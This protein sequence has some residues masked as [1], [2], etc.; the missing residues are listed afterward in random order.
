MA[1][2]IIMWLDELQWNTEM[3]GRCE[4]CSNEELQ[5]VLQYY[6]GSSI[7]SGLV[8]DAD[9]F[10]LNNKNLTIFSGALHY[11]RV[12][13]SYWEDRI[14][15]ISAMGLVAVETYV[16]WNLHEPEEGVYDFGD[17]DREFSPFLD[18]DL[19]I[20]KVY[21]ANLLLLIRP[22]PY[23][24]AEWEFGGL[25]SWLLRIPDIK[26][27]T[28]DEKYTSKVKAYFDKLLP[29]IAKWQF[30][31]GGPII[32][33][34]LENEYG[35]TGANDKEYLEFLRDLYISHGIDGLFFTSD[36]PGRSGDRGALDG[37][38]QTA[39][40]K[41]FPEV[42]LNV[43]RELQPDKPAMV[44]E[45]W[46]GWYDHWMNGRHAS[47]SAARFRNILERIITY[48]ASFNLYM[49]H[50]GTSF[51]FMSGANAASS[52]PTYKPQV[53]SYDYDA[54][55]TEAGDYTDKYTAVQELL[56]QYAPKKFLKADA[57]KETTK[58]AYPDVP[59][60][61][62]LNLDDLVAQV[63]TLA[64]FSFV[65]ALA[66][67][68]NFGFTI[69][70]R[71]FLYADN[72]TL[73]TKI[74]NT[75]PK[76]IELKSPY[77][78][79]TEQ[80]SL[81]Q[82]YQRPQVKDRM[83]VGETG[84]LL[85]LDI[86]D[87]T[88]ICVLQF[89]T[90][91]LSLS[92]LLLLPGC[93]LLPKCVHATIKKLNVT[94]RKALNSSNEM[95]LHKCHI[96]CFEKEDH[97]HHHD[98]LSRYLLQAVS[99]SFSTQP[100]DSN[101]LEL[102]LLHTVDV[103]SQSFL[104]LNSSS[105][106]MS[107]RSHLAMS[108]TPTSFLPASIIL[109]MCKCNMDAGDCV[110]ATDILTMEFLDINNGNGQ[111]YGFVLYR[112]NAATIGENS[113]LQIIGHVRDLAVVLIDGENITEPLT[114]KEQLKN[115]GFWEQSNASTTLSAEASVP[116]T[117]D[118]LVE[119]WGRVNY[120]RLDSGVF[121][122]RKGIVSGPVLIDGTAISDWQIFAL[123]F[124][125]KWL[126]SLTGWQPVDDSVRGPVLVRAIFDVDSAPNDTFIDM[127]D[128]GKGSVFLNGFPLG[129]Y[130]N[131]GPQRTLYV[132]APLLVQGSNEVLIFELYTP[133]TKVVFSDSPI[134]G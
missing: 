132:P 84:T 96:E 64:T 26:V 25:P 88:R 128:W 120:G 75:D 94:S 74:T 54:P 6:Q 83:F 102:T 13:P 77:K 99:S 18:L 29:I 20:Q 62:Q 14:A 47:T 57:P 110:N 108:S 5:P 109:E 45:Y 114:S 50:G 55:L 71:I 67:R 56:D 63:V 17:G 40:F 12:H 53:T 115:F 133:S 100:V 7:D 28:S 95:P 134:L 107:S 52:F 48:P 72:L 21:E 82:T 73:V 121:D 37:V 34:Q 124:K 61:G 65:T 41:F 101:P 44:M 81:N 112:K 1:L 8:A 10:H 30:I 43:L 68:D 119:N 131:L 36:T 2:P 24:C 130:F 92:F 58:V 42:Q 78:N 60:L 31:K 19:F 39:N 46:A 66:E 90:L 86:R 111:S 97:C 98:K 33:V 122:Q 117:L 22:G 113:V 91:F 116:H 87:D 35:G 123:Q 103:S 80:T 16:P 59:L 27:R 23:I 32:A 85:H 89:N 49:F 106:S 93:W 105:S 79:T 104:A 125:K 3:V 51:G 38:L 118:I 69:W 11:F 129:R 70:L 9:G 15:K 126:Q 4:Y 127:S 76:E